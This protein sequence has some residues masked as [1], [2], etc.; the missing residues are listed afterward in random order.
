MANEKS[1]RLSACASSSLAVL[2]RGTF[3]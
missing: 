3:D 1:A 2:I